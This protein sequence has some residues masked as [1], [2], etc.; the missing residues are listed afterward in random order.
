VLDSTV[1]IGGER[2]GKRALDVL[3][4]VRAV[5]GDQEAV[6]AA[7]TAGE[8]I[9]G[10]WRAR[11]EDR[12]A[13]REEFAEEVFARI[14]V[15]PMTLTTARIAGRVDGQCRASGVTV[16]VA[17]LWIGACALELGFAV[18]TANVRHYRLLPGLQVHLLE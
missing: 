13:R 10:I 5:L 14:P 3:E 1:L 6:I 18:A 15:M 9:H 8:L 16:P 17:D 4:G 12:R 7:V 2:A 11:Q